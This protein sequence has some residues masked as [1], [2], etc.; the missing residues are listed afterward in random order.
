[1]HRSLGYRLS[2]MLDIHEYAGTT[3]VRV[4]ALVYDSIDPVEAPGE[5]RG[6]LQAELPHVIV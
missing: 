3:E 4:T 6:D 5:P 1:M 2:R